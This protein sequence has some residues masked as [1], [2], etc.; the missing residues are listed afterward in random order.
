MTCLQCA[1]L[2]LIEVFSSLR[3]IVN[4]LALPTPALA[5]FI[6]HKIAVRINLAKRLRNCAFSAGCSSW[7]IFQWSEVEPQLPAS[8]PIK[9]KC[10]ND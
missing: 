10:I 9:S 3:E 6:C 7:T 1:L 8:F 5:I 4:V 2:A